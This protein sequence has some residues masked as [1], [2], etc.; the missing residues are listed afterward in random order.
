MLLKFIFI[1][2][3]IILTLSSHNVAAQEV[4]QNKDTAKV[5]RNIQRFSQ[6]RKFTKFL[7]R[8]IFRPIATKATITKSTKTIPL[9]PIYCDYDGK[10][11]RNINIVVIDPFGYTIQDTLITS[12]GFLPK[13][14]NEFH[15]K[16]QAFTIRNMLLI[17]TNTSFDSL[18]VKESERLIR[19]QGYIYDVLFN[20]KRTSETS[21]SVDI[22]I[23]VLD[24]WSLAPDFAL[25]SN[26]ITLGLNDKNIAG[27]GH[28]FNNSYD[29]NRANGNESILANYVIPNFKNTYISTTLNYQSDEEHNYISSLDIERPF[30]SPLTKWAGGL[31]I[32]RQLSASSLSNNEGSSILFTTRINTLDAWGAKA[33][34]IFK[35]NSVGRRTTKLIL[36]GRLLSIHFLEKPT[37]QYD[38]LNKYNDD[39]LWL[40]GIGIC[41]REY[42][43]DKYIF[44]FGVTEDVP[45]GRTYGIVAGYEL[46]NAERDY[47]GFRYATGNYYPFGFISTDIEYG[48]YVYGSKPQQGVFIASA[49]YFTGLFEIGNWKLRQFVQPELTI[50]IKR[51][52]TDSLTLKVNQE[53]NGFNSTALKGTQRFILNLQTQ[54]YAPWNLAGFRFGPYLVLSLGMLGNES[55]GFRNSQIYSQ[56]SVGFLIKNE[57]W[58]LNT[59][60]FSFSYYPTIPG[61]GENIFKSNK[62]KTTDFG[63]TNFDLGKPGT[64]VYQ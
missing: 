46:K 50:G 9:N 42:V 11:I 56:I 44:N 23:R 63:F 26:H 25:S 6:K 15:I 52:N 40:A 7:Y 53:F 20:F 4:H 18:K 21:D 34:Q 58:V 51:L 43:K 19:S 29:I 30:Y 54:S 60:Q 41:T 35:G 24:E 17:K 5:Y 49:N 12:Q 10:I 28:N 48:T 39:N 37:A 14:G 13:L 31:L 22:S 57:Y 32:S 64:V 45:V 33:W 38:S 2:L 16:T 36:S 3:F 8:L 59:L 62:I 27:L 61:N 47:L 55:T 1:S